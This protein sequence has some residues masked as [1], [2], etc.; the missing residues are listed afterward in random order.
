MTTAT[1]QLMINRSSLPLRL[2]LLA[3]F[4]VLLMASCKPT[5]PRKY[6]QPRKMEKILFDYHLAMATAAN[7]YQY[8]EDIRWLQA[9]YREK[10]FAK[11]GITQEQFD[12]S[13]VYYY[14]HADRLNKIYKNLQ[15]RFSDEG[16][17]LGVSIKQSGTEL[18]TSGDTAN[19]WKGERTRM[20]LPYK[21]H[22]LYSFNQKIDTTFHAGDQL[23]LHFDATFI[24][25]DGPHD[26]TAYLIVRYNND[27]IATQM[28]RI[29]NTMHYMMTINDPHKTGIKEVKGYFIMPHS[30]AD[31][32]SNN[33]R[34]IYLYDIHLV[35][36]RPSDNPQE[37]EKPTSTIINEGGDSS[38]DLLHS[39]EGMGEELVTSEDMPGVNRSKPHRAQG[40]HQWNI[41]NPNSGRKTP[42]KQR[43]S[44]PPPP[45][46]KGLP[47][48]RIK[49]GRPGYEPQT[50]PAEDNSQSRERISH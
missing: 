29:S 18:P 4:T 20:L 31:L 21:P 24:C 14:R 2:M 1:P 22:N 39:E 7:E 26:A 17:K 42:D 16:A 15:E 25:Q 35:R 33:Y 32:G 40:E 46:G 6:I 3:G 48:S 41:A 5:V 13:M 28:R 38:P 45:G 50:V 9:Q 10:V 43:V 37:E 34:V 47:P 23:A 27:S 44:E 19:I 11:H 49:Q 30:L 8:S 36:T 12:E